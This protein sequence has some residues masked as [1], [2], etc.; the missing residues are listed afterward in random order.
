LDAFGGFG[1]V[2]H[3]MLAFVFS[4]GLGAHHANEVQKHVVVVLAVKAGLHLLHG[5]LVGVTV[6]ERK[7][8]MDWRQLLANPRVLVQKWPLVALLL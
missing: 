8:T 6:G 2:V 5:L 7:D 3:T 4:G 1:G